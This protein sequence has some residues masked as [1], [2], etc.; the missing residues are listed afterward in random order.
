MMGEGCTTT[1]MLC[2]S[3]ACNYL[4]E[5]ILWKKK[6]TGFPQN[7]HSNLK[8]NHQSFALPCVAVHQTLHEQ[9]SHQ[10][11]PQAS[12]KHA[13]QQGKETGQLAVTQW[14]LNNSKPL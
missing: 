2:I 9:R 8:P 13:T 5:N 11:T 3:G 12:T 14:S 7:S 4:I 1:G 10:V 6:V